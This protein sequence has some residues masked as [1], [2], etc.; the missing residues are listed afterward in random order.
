M[1]L[2]LKWATLALSGEELKEFPDFTAEQEKKLNDYVKSTIDMF[3]KGNFHDMILGM[4][5]LR[6][7]IVDNVRPENLSP[8]F[9][10]FL[11]DQE[12]FHWVD[13]VV[14]RKEPTSFDLEAAKIIID[15]LKFMLKNND[16]VAQ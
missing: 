11:M 5:D 1:D 14:I 4:I 16:L 2:L 13:E 3:D 12:M 9:A 6:Q 15:D 10:D 7:Y 8:N